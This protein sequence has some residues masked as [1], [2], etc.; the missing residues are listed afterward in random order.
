MARLYLKDKHQK[1]IADK[2]LNLSQSGRFRKWDIWSDFI[3]MTACTISLPDSKR[4][5][6]RGEMYQKIA[7]KYNKAEME[8]FFSLFND[9]VDAYEDDQE[10]DLLGELFMLLKLGNDYVGQFFTPYSIC[11]TMSGITVGDLKEKI[12]QK[13]YVTVNDPCCGAGALLIAFAN[14]AKS[15][16]INYQRQIKFVAQDID[17]IA[18]MMCYIQISLIGCAGYVIVGNTL[19]TPPTEPLSNQNVWFT[20]LYFLDVWHWRRVAGVIKQAEKESAAT[21]DTII[22]TEPEEK[23]ETGRSKLTFF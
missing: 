2:I 21:G 5:E 19:T 14:E 1:R 3:T 23:K 17:F 22:E 4:R 8:V 9:L 11:E 6:E 15:Q 16:G 10:Q 13:G 12:K 20:P 18:A 7:K